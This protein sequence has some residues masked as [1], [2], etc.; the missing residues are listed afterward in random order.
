[1]QHALAGVAGKFYVLGSHIK[2]L[3]SV[4]SAR[5]G[6]PKIRWGNDGRKRPDQPMMPRM[7]DSFMMRRSSPLSLT[8][9]PDHLPNRTRSPALTS[10]GTS[11]PFSSR[12]P[13]P[14]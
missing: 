10:S 7:S 9:V 13:E 1:A 4:P 3:L 6:R 5:G 14:A 12:A 8:S 11:L 2:L